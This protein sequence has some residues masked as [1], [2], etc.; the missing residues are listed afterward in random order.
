MSP[1]QLLTRACVIALTLVLTTLAAG[2]AAG[3]QTTSQSHP[4]HIHNGTCAT[5]G[6]IA[7]N[8]N[9]VNAPGAPITSMGTPVTG[10]AR[11][12]A[13]PMAG[14]GQIVAESVTVIQVHLADLEKAPFAI[15]VHESLD[16]ISH[17]I[18]C[19]D[20]TGTITDN[21]LKI[22]VNELNGSGLSGWATLKDDGTGMTTVTVE[23][24][25]GAAAGATP[26]ASP[27]A[28][29]ST[30]QSASAAGGSEVS[31]SPTI[32]MVDIAFKQKEFTIP[33]NTDVTVT[34]DNTGATMHNFSITDHNNSGV[35]NLNISVDVQPGETKTVTINAP[36]G[37]YYYF[38]NVPGHEA[39]GMYGT[40][41]V[42]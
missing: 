34:L 42:K 5:L 20:I 40:M 26:N 35:K 17:Y 10:T 37:D 4:A 30:G 8:L 28:S 31:T 12:A 24:T 15:N 33:A 2:G 19:G 41:H 38:C 25:R 16:Q 9:D 36:A 22:P 27:S 13:T 14:E 1:N 11:A 18:A 7:W 21:S 3:A 6:S 32:T 29:G 39:A 23:L